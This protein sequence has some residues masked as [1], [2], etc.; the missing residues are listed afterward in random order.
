MTGAQLQEMAT[1]YAYSFIS[2]IE[3]DEED[4]ELRRLLYD[5][6]TIGFMQGAEVMSYS[7]K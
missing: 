1:S 7:T 6:Y 5:I 4:E 2:E 3:F